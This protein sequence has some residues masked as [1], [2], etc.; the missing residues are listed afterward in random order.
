MKTHRITGSILGL[1][2]GDA[3]GAPFEG[4]PVERAV[5]LLIGTQSV[6]GAKAGVMADVPDGVTY[7]GV[8]AT[9]ERMQKQMAAAYFKLPEMRKQFKVMKRTVD[10]LAKAAES[11]PKKDAA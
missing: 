3:F 7:L 4:G 11:A 2:L 5:W 6:L 8:P 1:A 10:K 9:P